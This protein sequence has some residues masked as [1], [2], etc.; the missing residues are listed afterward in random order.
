MGEIAMKDAEDVASYADAWIEI[1]YEA[2]A[3]RT[4]AVASYA[5]AWIEMGTLAL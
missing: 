4:L 2:A 1:T 3:G 5:D